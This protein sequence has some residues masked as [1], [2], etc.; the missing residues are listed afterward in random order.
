MG[1]KNIENSILFRKIFQDLS[2]NEVRA[3][4]TPPVKVNL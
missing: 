1:N 3:A 2:F 4:V